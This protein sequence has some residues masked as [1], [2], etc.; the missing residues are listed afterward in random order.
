MC[1]EFSFLCLSCTSV[2]TNGFDVFI[3]LSGRR[4]P[5]RW[6]YIVAQIMWKDTV[7]QGRAP[8]L[9]E[10]SSLTGRSPESSDEKSE[11]QKGNVFLRQ[12]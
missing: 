8:H 10:K 4:R 3:F 2:M 11:L 5:L 6:K 12:E 1:T 9:I 7:N